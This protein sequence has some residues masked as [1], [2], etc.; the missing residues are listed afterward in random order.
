MDT[1]LKKLAALTGA[2]ALFVPA[3]SAEWYDPS[4]WFGDS[5]I[6]YDEEYLELDDEAT[7]DYDYS[8]T[9]SDDFDQQYEYSTAE[10]DHDEEWYD[11][12]DWFNDDRA[13][14]F[15]DRAWES[16]YEHDEDWYE[17]GLSD[18]EWGADFETVGEKDFW[19]T[20]FQNDD[21]WDEEY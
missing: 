20:D 5:D 11:P 4:D 14:S 17:T 8:G 15:E 9:G 13:V 19:D 16:T 7:V 3:V 12:T 6:G 21:F 1:K 18:G 2:F 10:G